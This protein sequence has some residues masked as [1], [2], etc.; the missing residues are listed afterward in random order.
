M[1]KK[2]I[3]TGLIF[4]VL[5]NGLSAAAE[6]S[7]QSS[8]QPTR[9]LGIFIGAN[10]GGRER[11]VLRYA[12]SD[13]QS[14]SW[15]FAS[16]GG[17]GQ[18]DNVL[19]VEP[20]VRDINRQ[21]DNFE[22]ITAQAKQNSQRTEL[23][24]YYSGHSDENGIFLNRERYGYQE[25]RARINSVQADMRIVILDSCSSGAMTRVKGGVKTQP[26]LFDNSVSAEGYAILT[27]SSHDEVSQESDSIASSYF[28]HSLRAGLRGAADSVGDGRVTLNEL[29]RFAYTE[30]LANTET[31]VYGAQHPS[32]DI[33]I[34]GS[35]DVVLTDI[36]E[37]SASLLIGE[38]IT[39][40]VSI[41]DG[42]DFLIAELTKVTRRPI[43]LGLEPGVYRI[44]LQRGDSFFQT[45]VTLSE[46]KRTGLNMGNFRMIAGAAGGLSRGDGDASVEDELVLLANELRERAAQ[47]AEESS[48]APS[49][50][51]NSGGGSSETGNTI[52][53]VNIQFVPG[54]NL[55]GAYGN[56]K[57][58]NNFLLG[59]LIAA[60]Y[61]LNGIGAGYIGLINTGFSHGVKAAGIFNITNGNVN[62]V[63]A[64]G[65]F[66]IAASD[67]NG[68]L[69][70]GIFNIV[71]DN[72]KGIQA[73]GIFNI[74]S[75]NVKGIQ[76]AGIF[77]IAGNVD[78]IQAGLVNINKGG[79]GLMAGLVNVSGSEK[80]FPVGLVNFIE[81]GIFHPAVYLDDSRFMNI[82]FR[83]GSKYFY[84]IFSSGVNVDSFSGE[85]SLVA[86]RAGIGFELPI[87]KA[88]IDID[89]T[90]GGIFNVGRM[91]DY[92]KN[93]DYDDD[94]NDFDFDYYENYTLVYQTRLT[95]GY[96][97]FRHFGIFAG[98]SYDF[99]CQP[100]G[101]FAPEI[102]GDVIKA[103][104]Y[105]YEGSNY[106]HK[107]GF[108]G[109]IQ[110]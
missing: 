91:A 13:A 11:A 32:Y 88:F 98:I 105:E 57:A 16:M 69:V 96:K 40:R 100:V 54:L 66:N 63:H 42:S 68:T 77:N 60:G 74:A 78:G 47:A 102:F 72:L 25:L 45:S 37:V 21:L 33:Q 104:T 70:S 4:L 84:T 2:N 107:F 90:A 89:I 65:I 85:N 43:E 51:F 99:Y 79:T 41:R 22:K 97:F 44:T 109:G 9:R 29:Y 64:A 31:S 39:G 71:D 56:Q 26:F 12:V 108:F 19:L 5:I 48:S 58:T 106:A 3:L 8:G 1:F 15:I 46:N 95:F 23:V 6:D 52:V 87:N 17:I 67:V 75:G 34:S 36:K 28:T 86:S 94:D 92:V 82:S 103:E 49:E 81:N 20:S 76:A 83:S 27:S 61:N 93:Y 101:S 30:T 14:V 50:D 24:F 55:L 110:F 80:V 59:I 73:A 53:P 35:G 7:Q 38:D 10:N 62:G 18:S